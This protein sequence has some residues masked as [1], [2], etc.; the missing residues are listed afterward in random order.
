MVGCTYFVLSSRHLI[1]SFLLFKNN[2]YSLKS[3]MLEG[4]RALEPAELYKYCYSE[5]VTETLGGQ[6]SVSR[7]LNTTSSSTWETE[8]YRKF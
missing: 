2:F 8:S 3:K 4:L 7:K 5:P 1:V 6:E